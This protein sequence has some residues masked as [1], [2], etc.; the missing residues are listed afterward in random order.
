MREVEL[1]KRVSK[2]KKPE[3]SGSRLT[4]NASGAA[5]GVGTQITFSSQNKVGWVELCEIQQGGGYGI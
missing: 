2:T 1:V 4:P 3:N 5:I